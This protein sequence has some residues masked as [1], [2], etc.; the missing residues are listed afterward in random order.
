M[1]EMLDRQTKSGLTDAQRARPL[2][3]GVTITYKYHAQ[4]LS[5]NGNPRRNLLVR[6]VL[7]GNS[8]GDEPFMASFV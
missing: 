7:V 1:C 8:D 3:I 5:T 2:R 4:E 6:G